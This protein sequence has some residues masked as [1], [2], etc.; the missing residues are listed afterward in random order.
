MNDPLELRETD[1]DKLDTIMLWV[2]EADKWWAS[3]DPCQKMLLLK[4]MDRA[5]L[6]P[7]FPPIS[8]SP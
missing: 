7:F 3:L 4:G 6:H 2:E 8:Q 1:Q 5:G